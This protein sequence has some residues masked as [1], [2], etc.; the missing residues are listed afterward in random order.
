MLSF[1]QFAFGLQLFNN[2]SIFNFE[3]LLRALPS[4]LSTASC[5]FLLSEARNFG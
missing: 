3:L 4:E 2:S 1:W 5:Q